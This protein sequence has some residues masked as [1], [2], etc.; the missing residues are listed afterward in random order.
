MHISVDGEHHSTGLLFIGSGAYEP[1]GFVPAWRPQLDDGLL[2]LRLLDVGKP[3][4]VAR[5]A[6]A[7]LTGKLAT[8]GLY[9]ERRVRS[10][11]IL[12][13]SGSTVLAR[14]GEISEGEPNIAFTV[15]PRA[16]TVFRPQ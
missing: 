12:I 8:S 6:L 4:A 1:T 2:D 10:V 15:L 11:E 9:V 7:L 5:F 13:K 3:F 16:L 14:D